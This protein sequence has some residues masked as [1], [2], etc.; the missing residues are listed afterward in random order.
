MPQT[1]D[2]TPFVIITVTA[3]IF[4][5]IVANHKK[6]PLHR[7]PD[8]SLLN[9]PD[10]APPSWEQELLLVQERLD[11]ESR[12]E[13]DPPSR[14]AIS[15]QV[16]PSGGESRKSVPA[17]V[18]A[19]ATPEPEPS[20]EDWMRS[21][22]TVFKTEDEIWSAV[23]SGRLKDGD[24]FVVEMR[25]R[26]VDKSWMNTGLWFHGETPASSGVNFPVPE[27]MPD[28]LVDGD[29]IRVSYW[30]S[31][32]Q[33]KPTKVKWFGLED[34]W[35]MTLERG[36]FEDLL[37]YGAKRIAQLQAA[38]KKR[39]DDA[40]AEVER[41]EREKSLKEREKSLK[42]DYEKFLDSRRTAPDSR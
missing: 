16:Q 30:A 23:K 32:I 14:D 21:R 3:C 41:Q 17:S 27:N 22:A 42:R 18:E 7:R 1:R 15:I 4:L 11:A 12:A 20:F 29:L 25:F 33:A 10:V 40:A 13:S 24:C 31:Q 38:E 5:G 35:S 2:R 36:R 34:Q 8:S 6:E 26:E 37:S 28:Y 9:S 39:L 19:R